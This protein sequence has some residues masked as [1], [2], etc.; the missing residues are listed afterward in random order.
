MKKEEVPSVHTGSHIAGT[1]D[2]SS[3]VVRSKKKKKKKKCKA[4]YEV[5]RKPDKELEIEKVKN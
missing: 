3:T 1:G 2:D 4:T 5:G